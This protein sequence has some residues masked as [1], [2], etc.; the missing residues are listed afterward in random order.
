MIIQM[1]SVFNITIAGVIVQRLVL[2]PLSPWERPRFQTGLQLSNVR[3]RK[4]TPRAGRV[5]PS[6]T[7]LRYPPRLAGH[8]IR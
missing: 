1:P 6:P 3:P 5:V 4:S 2:H 8:R 7:D